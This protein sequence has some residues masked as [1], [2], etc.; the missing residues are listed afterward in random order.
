MLWAKRLWC[1]A[2][3]RNVIAIVVAVVGFAGTSPSTT[4]AV[5]AAAAPSQH[6]NAQAGVTDGARLQREIKLLDP[7][8]VTNAD[9]TLVLSPPAYVSRQVDRADMARFLGGLATIDLK[10]KTGELVSTTNHRLV[11]PKETAFN[12]QWNWTG[13]S[14]YWWGVQSWFSEYW[15]LKIEAAYNMGAAGAGLCA[16]VAAALGAAPIALVCGVAAAV[17]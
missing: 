1:N 10:I 2:R 6:A 17:I 5:L 4:S 11:N 15:T 9:G 7:Y 12:I 8:V 14:Y 13:R 16:V 3:V